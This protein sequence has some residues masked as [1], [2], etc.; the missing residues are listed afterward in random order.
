MT[1]SSTNPHFGDG[2]LQHLYRY[3][4]EKRGDKPLPYSK[5]IDPTD[6]AA[7]ILP[8]V[9]LTEVLEEGRFRYRLAGAAIESVSGMS[10]VGRYLDEVLL[11]PYLE[12]LLSLYHEVIQNRRAL[13]TESLYPPTV[14]QTE[15]YTKRLMMPLLSEEESVSM[16]L[17][18]QVFEAGEQ[19]MRGRI[20][21]GPPSAFKE[22]VRLPL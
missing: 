15:H 17:S 21:P 11:P 6:L 20:T 22:T 4:L 9:M 2:R 18:G 12:Y 8:H 16:I 19:A 1:D 5:N 14:K 13:Y 3:W 10:L 7:E